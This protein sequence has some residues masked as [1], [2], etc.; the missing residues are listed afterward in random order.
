MPQEHR[1]TACHPS[2]E[3]PQLARTIP[4]VNPADTRDLGRS[5][6]EVTQLG[7]GAAPLGDLF[8]TVG[9][10][11]AQAALSAAW[12]AGVRYFDTAPFYGRGLSERRLGDFLRT[13]PT[14]EYVLSTK[15]GR[16]LQRALHP[17]EIDR[18][19]WAGGLA[20]DIQFDYTYDG[21]MRSYADSLQRLGL[22]RV[23]VLVIY[24]LDHR[25]H[26]AA[27]RVAAYLAQLASS[28]WRA[29]E[30]LRRSGEVRA[31]GA[32][33]NEL[34]MIG[35]LLDLFDL[36][37]FLVAMRYTLLDQGAL[38]EELPRCTDQGVGVVVGAVF[39][40]GILATGPVPGAKY[41]YVDAPEDVLERVRRIEAVCVRYQVPLAAAALQFPLGHPSVASVIPGGSNP[42]HIKQTVD[43]LHISIPDELWEELRS[44]G[45]IRP[46]A[47]VP[48]VAFSGQG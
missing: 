29:L 36:D 11:E 34:G 47:P 33:I 3:A 28:G 21:I 32:G 45:L 24:D 15:V 43:A 42:G 17:A 12:D 9:E 18:G 38:I 30:E 39:N 48:R 27:E 20:F 1:A 8:V 31:I 6:L 16:V 44:D 4:P 26:I 23:D 22:P 41:D 14:S 40:S 19:I 13:K 46:D 10:A 2:W 7:Y 25:H 5:G 37:F 35:R